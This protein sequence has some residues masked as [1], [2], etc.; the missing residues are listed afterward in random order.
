MANKVIKI[1]ADENNISIIVDNETTLT[2]EKDKKTISSDDVFKSLKYFNEV[3]L[4]SQ[5]GQILILTFISRP[6]KRTLTKLS[7]SRP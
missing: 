7:S 2:I 5:H 1:I 3:Y 6:S 4:R